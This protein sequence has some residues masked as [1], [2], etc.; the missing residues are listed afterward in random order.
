MPAPHKSV[1]L[2]S[3]PSHPTIN[4]HVP[5]VP[6]LE[7]LKYID[8]WFEYDV[9]TGK[10]YKFRP[11]RQEL[12]EIGAYNNGYLVSRIL[13]REIYNHHICWYLYYK[14]WPVL[15]IDHEDRNRSNNK[16]NN[17]REATYEIQNRNHPNY[18]LVVG[19]NPAGSTKST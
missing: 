6:S 1:D 18:K 19:S 4:Y 14:K 7:E 16:I 5:E 9:E 15:Q 8:D 13:G 2:G 3:T 11:A 10:L 17:L 12:V